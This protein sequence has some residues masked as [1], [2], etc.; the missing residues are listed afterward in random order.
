MSQPVTDSVPTHSEN[1]IANMTPFEERSSNDKIIVESSQ[2][3]VMTLKSFRFK[4]RTFLSQFCREHSRL[5]RRSTRKR[6]QKKWSR[7]NCRR[8]DSPWHKATLR[9]IEISIFVSSI[10]SK[11]RAKK[12]TMWP[13]F[14]A[15]NLLWR[16]ETRPSDGCRGFR[17]LR[18]FQE[19]FTRT[20]WRKS[21]FAML[22]GT[23]GKLRLALPFPRNANRARNTPALD[24]TDSSR[25]NP[26]CSTF[27]VVYRDN[28]THQEHKQ[29]QSLH[30]ALGRTNGA[31]GLDGNLIPRILLLVW[32][33][34]VYISSTHN[35]SNCHLCFMSFC[36]P[37]LHSGPVGASARECL[38][39][40]PNTRDH[41]LTA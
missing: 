21:C 13:E 10:S 27:S 20:W 29:R 8:E 41:K 31:V 6:E 12:I 11:L 32:L 19:V 37:R 34:D 35:A 3:R 40:I 39:Q 5:Y 16:S 7:R 36:V 14:L 38:A 25:L 22:L 33:D 2:P 28:E 30:N 23:F 4:T 24:G 15:S 17:E 1:S 26:R 18:V 9:T